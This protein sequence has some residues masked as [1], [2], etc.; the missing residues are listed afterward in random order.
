[1]GYRASGDTEEDG[2]EPAEGF[3]RVGADKESE[4]IEEAKLFARIG[5][6][7][8]P[9]ALIHLGLIYTV[10]KG[11][12]D[13]DLPE[14]T[15]S[16]P[17]LTWLWLNGAAVALAIWLWKGGRFPIRRGLWLRG[18]TAKLLIILWLSGS[19]A[20]FTLPALLREAAEFLTTRDW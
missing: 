8:V 1:M 3:D 4:A 10:L 9:V 19:I 14:F 7:A 2:F 13:L 6:Y 17:L 11:A 16:N 5:Y 18:R 15:T 20:W 12:F